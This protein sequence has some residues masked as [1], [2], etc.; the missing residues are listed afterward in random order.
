MTSSFLN[1]LTRGASEEEQADAEQ[2]EAPEVLPTDHAAKRGAALPEETEESKEQR[3]FDRYD[4]NH[5]GKITVQELLAPRVKS[6]K[7][8]DVNGD[9]LQ[10]FDEWSISTRKR[11]KKLDLNGDGV[12]SP[13]ELTASKKPARRKQ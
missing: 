7:K 2:S 12:I 1:D 4:K 11:F 9:K 8:L 10:S 5:D 6:F 13:R 3:R